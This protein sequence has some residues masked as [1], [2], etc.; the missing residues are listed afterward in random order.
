[1]GRLPHITAQDAPSSACW[2]LAENAAKC[3][4]ETCRLEDVIVDCPSPG[5]TMNETVKQVFQG[6]VDVDQEQVAQNVDAAHFGATSGDHPAQ[7]VSI[8]EPCAQAGIT[9]W[10]ESIDPWRF[11]WSFKVPWAAE[12]TVLM[13]ERI[14]QGPPR[15]GASW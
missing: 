12:A 10:I 6:I 8:V 4:E 1:L 3:S 2:Y 15:Q 9:W 13:H 7:A 14:R 5:T 11:G